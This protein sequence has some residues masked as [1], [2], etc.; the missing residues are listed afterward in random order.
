MIRY[1]LA[2]LI[3]IGLAASCGCEPPAAEDA[4]RIEPAGIV[5]LESEEPAGLN[6]APLNNAPIDS[7]ALGNVPFANAPLASAPLG[8]A[9]LGTAPPFPAPTEPGPG[10]LP[11]GIQ[12]ALEADGYWTQAQVERWLRESLKLVQL[13][14]APAGN[15]GYSGSGVSQDGRT[16][17]LAVKQVLGGIRCDF[18]FGRGG[19]GYTAV[20]KPVPQ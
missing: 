8:S 2:L 13:Q 15:H 18:T 10:Q 11:A 3:A 1:V 20:G 14:I 5:P 4:A 6:S 12:I 7:P 16:Y 19:G 17:Q 9:P